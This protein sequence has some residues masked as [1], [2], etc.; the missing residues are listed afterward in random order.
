MDEKAGAALQPPPHNLR[1]KLPQQHP[2]V[3]S[4]PSGPQQTSSDHASDSFEQEMLQ[5][6]QH[7]CSAVPAESFP[8]F[9][10]PSALHDP[11]HCLNCRQS[12]LHSSTDQKATAETAIAVQSSEE[13]RP[14]ISTATVQSQEP[15][16]THA[17]VMHT[18]A[19]L[20]VATA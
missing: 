3:A 12:K 14:R 13:A 4:S 19:H 7:L 11:Y 18:C 6:S 16:R 2:F 5:R 10:S 17:H 15:L 9:L 8:V 20:A 1:H